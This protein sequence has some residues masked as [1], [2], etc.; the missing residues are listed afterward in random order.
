MAGY[1]S[2]EMPVGHEVRAQT[3]RDIDPGFWKSH[4]HLAAFLLTLDVS[5]YLTLPE[6]FVELRFPSPDF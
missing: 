6:I 5:M 1:W 3:L 2:F 4:W